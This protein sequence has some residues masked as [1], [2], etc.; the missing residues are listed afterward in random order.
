MAMDGYAYI[1]PLMIA[2]IVLVA[3]GLKKA[4]GHVDAPLETVPAVAL[5]GGAALYLVGHVAF[6]LRMTG[7]VGRERLVAAGVCLALIP[8]ATTA[9]ALLAVIALLAATGGLVAFETIR[10]RET[11]GEIRERRKPRRRREGPRVQRP[12]P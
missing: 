10:Y 11:R 12:A 4:L 6:K 8:L 7:S 3:F 1:H 2:G 9:D 5:C